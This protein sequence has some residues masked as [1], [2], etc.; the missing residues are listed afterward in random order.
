MATLLCWTPGSAATAAVTGDL[1]LEETLQEAGGT[2]GPSWCEL[3]ST[4]I[5]LLFPIPA[6]SFHGGRPVLP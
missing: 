3:Y 5:G 4:M 6:V 2:Q 1:Q